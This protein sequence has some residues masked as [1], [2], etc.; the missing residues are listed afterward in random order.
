MENQ[1]EYTITVSDGVDEK[2]LNF[3]D[4]M[5]FVGRLD[6]DELSKFFVNYLS[7][8]D[9]ILDENYVSNHKRWIAR[10]GG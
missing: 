8:L 4:F 9:S 6:I 10:Y 5:S 1:N 2:A 7:S 3:L